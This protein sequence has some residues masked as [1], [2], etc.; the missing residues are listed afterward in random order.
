MKMQKPIEFVKGLLKRGRYSFTRAEA[1]AALRRD[2]ASLSQ[3]L[4]RL[5][6]RGWVKSFS[7]GFYIA[8]DV[9]HQG[10]GMLDPKWFVDDW[11]RHVGTGYYVGTLSAA[12]LHG[13]AHQRPAV[14]QVIVDRRLRSVRHTAFRMDTFYKEAISPCMWVKMKSPAGYFRVGTPEITAYDVIAY[15]RACPSLDHAATVMVELGD[16]LRV[17]QL[18]LLGQHGCGTAQLQRLG[19]MLER[20]GWEEKCGGVEMALAGRRMPWRLLEPRMA[21]GG[22]RNERWHIVE[23]TDVEPDIEL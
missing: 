13:A 3:A 21:P 5:T 14:F 15:R 16:A 10:G 23:N 6:D 17:A 11:A 18:K 4:K 12:A 7:R 2:G 9:Q 20:V 19:W 22:P 1:A 8:L